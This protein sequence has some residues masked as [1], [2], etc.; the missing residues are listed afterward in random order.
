MQ[1]EL[2]LLGLSF[3]LAVVLVV[4]VLEFWVVLVVSLVVVVCC[5]C[6]GDVGGLAV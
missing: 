4:V 3:E 6:Y 2:V 1:V 5:E